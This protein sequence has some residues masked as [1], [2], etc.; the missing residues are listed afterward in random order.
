VLSTLIV[1]CKLFY[2]FGEICTNNVNLISKRQHS[3]HN[4][5]KVGCGSLT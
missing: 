5:T 1:V 2:V 3:T 4:S